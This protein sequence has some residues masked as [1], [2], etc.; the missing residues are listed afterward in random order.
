MKLPCKYATLIL[1]SRVILS[2]MFF[3]LCAETVRAIAPGPGSG[4]GGGLGGWSFS[5]TNWLSNAG[6]P[7]LSFTNLVNVT[8]A[9]DGNALLLDTTGATPASLVYK[10]IE[11]GG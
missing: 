7:P 1:A 10:T 5:D 2:L 3:G 9:G 4:V 6:H 11:S 8:N